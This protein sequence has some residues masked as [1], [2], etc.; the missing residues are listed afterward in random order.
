[1]VLVKPKEREYYMSK[2]LKENLDIYKEVVYRKNTSVV[3]IIDGRS[4]EGKT[5]LSFQV[6]CYLF[7]EFNL[8]NVAFTP[9]QFIEALQ[10]AKKGEV[11]IFDEAMIISNRAA[12]SSL[13]RAVVYMLSVIR[14][15]QIFVILNINSVFDLD[16]NLALHRADFLL[17]VYSEGGKLGHRGRYAVFPKAKNKLLHLYILGK[18]Y[19]SYSKPRAVFI[20]RFSSYFVLDE[21]EY[22]KEKIS[23]INDFYK[24]KDMEK[25]GA[26]AQKQ[27]DILI[28]FVKGN[29]KI[30][31]DQLADMIHTSKETVKRALRV[32][33][34]TGPE[35]EAP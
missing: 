5:T 30:T 32:K 7:P 22:E 12:M 33:K 21:E 11:I 19:Y 27:R 20:D 18:K 16:R 4:G 23:A 2:K 1:M 31:I 29:H 3:G 34:E 8:K 17:H 14:S 28:R 6:A 35:G 10:K 24:S 15:K 13:N 25:G 9:E 26:K